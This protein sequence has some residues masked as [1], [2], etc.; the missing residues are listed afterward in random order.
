MT[1]YCKVCCRNH[2]PERFSLEGRR[3]HVCKSCMKL[4]REQ[5]EL[6]ELTDEMSGYLAQANISAK[7][8]TRLRVLSKSPHATVRAQAAALLEAARLHPHRSKRMPYLQEKAPE[9]YAALVE[10]FGMDASAPVAE[11]SPRSD[12]GS[13]PVCTSDS[14]SSG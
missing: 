7:N 2:P 5:R 13:D 4:P 1:T 3:I 6:R 10:A 11:A 8:L 9:V 12:E 14:A